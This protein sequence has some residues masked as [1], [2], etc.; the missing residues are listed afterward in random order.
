MDKVID[1]ELFESNNSVFLIQLIELQSGNSFVQI[2][3]TYKGHGYKTQTIKISSFFLK[4]IISTLQKY[5]MSISDN[6][7][8]KKDNPIED[9][10]QR[11]QEY[12]LKGVL[13]KDLCLIFDLSEKT[14]TK[15]L[16]EKGLAILHDSENKLISKRKYFKKKR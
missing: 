15:V 13:I 7:I 16:I 2:D 14:I 5:Q 12:Y 11:I 10:N 6:I 9:I 8:I 1:S 3:Q 4:D